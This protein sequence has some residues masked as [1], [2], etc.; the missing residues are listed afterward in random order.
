MDLKSWKSKAEGLVDSAS[1]ITGVASDTVSKMLDEFNAALPT[2]RALGF[3]VDSLHFE[4]G[5]LPEIRARLT[6]SADD[7]DVKAIDG[8][9]QKKSEQKTLVALLKGLQTAYNLRDQL[10]DLGL[11]T[12]EI[13]AKLGLPPTISIGFVKPAV[14]PSPADALV[15]PAA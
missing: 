6:A 10:G 5:V 2:M 4:A 1:Q 14:V 8:L 15:K 3:K 13:D 11:K 7:V 9:I 12:V